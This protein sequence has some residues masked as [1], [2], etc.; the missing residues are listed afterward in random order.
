MSNQITVAIVGAGGRGRNAYGKIMKNMP[1]EFKVVAAAD[2]I[3]ERLESISN[4]HNIPENM[5]FTTAEEMLSKERLADMAF[6]CTQDRD[7]Y[8]HA[9][10]ALEKGYHLLLEKPISPSLKECKA[11]AELANKKNLMVVVCHVL[12][13]TPFYTAL[14]DVIDSGRIGR[15]VTVTAEEHVGYWHQA[16]SFVRG[17]WRNST[18]AC[19][20][21]LAKCCHDM[22]ILLW[23]V[24]KK[25]RK[26]SS[27]GSLSNFKTEM[28]PAGSAD[29]CFDCD[30]ETRKSCPYDCEKIYL[31][32]PRGIRSGKSHWPTNIVNIHPTEENIT[33]ALKTGPYG[34]CVYRCDNDVVDNQVV[35]LLLE[36]DVTINF[37]M[38]AFTQKMTR[39][40]RVR[41]TQ[42]EITAVMNENKIIVSEFGKEDEIIDTSARPTGPSGSGAGHGG[43][44]AGIMRGIYDVYRN[45]VV[46]K[47]LSSIDVSVES[48]LVALA[49]EESRVNGGQVVDMDEWASRF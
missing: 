28:A 25:C 38:S 18:E 41:G 3:P 44:D 34:R 39:S 1:E 4:D 21:I 16:H 36:D 6:I 33:E 19:P 29:R 5:R 11:I 32:G 23:L 37:T 24:G 48:H 10:A 45:N 8:G 46:S 42:G 2:L 14:K 22:D 7:H 12:R 47:S 40:I 43:G 13:Y 27:F 26:V 35:N 49:A 15:I 30:P 31:D 9:M 20:M 17:N